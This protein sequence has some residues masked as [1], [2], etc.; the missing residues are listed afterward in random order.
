MCIFNAGRTRQERYKQEENKQDDS[1]VEIVPYA[2]ASYFYTRAFK[3]YF[4]YVNW[5]GLAN[6]LQA[7]ATCYRTFKG[8]KGEE[9]L[10][11]YKLAE[12]C[13]CWLGDASGLAI[14][15]TRI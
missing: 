15:W 4:K 13:C 14:L 2:A 7:M 1:Q 10:D 6:V 11:L 9:V 3:I 12:E 8:E 5:G